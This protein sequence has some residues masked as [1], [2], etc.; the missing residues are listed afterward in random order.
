MP[1]SINLANEDISIE[2]STPS[3]NAEE[4]QAKID[5]LRDT[6]VN[7]S[8]IEKKTHT[9]VKQQLLEIIEDAK[10]LKI[11]RQELRRMMNESFNAKGPRNAM[12]SESYL[13]R[14]LPPE[15]KYDEKARSDYKKNQKLK[16]KYDEY[17]TKFSKGVAEAAK[18]QAESGSEELQQLRNENKEQKGEIQSLR[19][20]VDKLKEEEGGREVWTAIGILEMNGSRMP[21]KITVNTKQKKIDHVELIE[22]K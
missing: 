11:E 19:K 2:I 13:R 3:Q 17:E 12:I 4:L 7:F 10:R 15:Y 1:P 6:I 16:Q 5:N 21:L 22:R 9:D 20:E 18:E 14:L 8:N